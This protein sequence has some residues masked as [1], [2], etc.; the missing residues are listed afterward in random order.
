MSD[1]T[2]NTAH[3]QYELSIE[4]EI[5]FARYRRQPNAQGGDTVAILHVEAPVALR[6]T[7]ASGRLM[8]GIIELARAKN[9]KLVPLCSYAAAW[10][11]RH[12][13]TA[14]LLA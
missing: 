6:G 8:Q 11:K 12:P 4:G 3:N 10:M 9:E 13:E 14:D 5:V 1:V 7:G 2:D